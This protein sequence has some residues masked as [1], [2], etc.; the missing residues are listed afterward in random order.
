[1]KVAL[2]HHWIMSYRGGERVLEQIAALFERAPIYTLTHDVAIDVPGLVNHDIRTSFLN[3]LP[4]IEKLYKHLLPLHPLAISR[5]RIADDVELLL[6]SD[7]SLIK[8]IPTSP[9]TKHVCYCHS[10]PRYLWEVIEDYKKTSL[11]TRLLLD[12]CL[13]A[14]K[15]FDFAA[16]Q[17]VDHFIAN[18][19]F[20]ASRISKYYGRE[21]DVVYRPVAV[22]QF[23]AHQTRDD[24]YLVLS[25]LVPYKRID[26]AVKAF[27]GTNRRLVVI[28]DGSERA[29]LEAIAT[30]NITFHGRQPFAAVKQYFETAKAF[31]FPGIEDFGIAP[32]ESQAAGCPV[33]A[34]GAG[35]ALETVIDHETG[36]FF[37]SQT[38]ESLRDAIEHFER[39]SIE[40][41]A[42]TANAQ[43]FCNQRFQTEYLACLQRYTNGAVDKPSPVVIRTNSE[44]CLALN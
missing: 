7:A 35:G 29:N 38:V 41:D 36:L 8:A 28:G 42:C 14:L 17:R 27:A 16:A 21:S 18:S 4:Q 11:S 3:R 44:Q 12:R 9:S 31:I 24:F 40:V 15:R 30:P 37:K 10:P 34:L 25:E 39:T 22:D 23:N 6:S 20:V 5:M 13:P 26:I 43:R 19:K 33:I 2:A 32:V 1:M